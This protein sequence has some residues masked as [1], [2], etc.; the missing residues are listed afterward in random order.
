MS[1]I[2]RCNTIKAEEILLRDEKFKV[3]TKRFNV[4]SIRLTL[5][6]MLQICIDHDRPQL[7]VTPGI[8]ILS[9]VGSRISPMSCAQTCKC[10]WCLSAG[11]TGRTKHFS[12]LMDS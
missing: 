5:D 2:G 12:V 1:N 9:T 7:T 11:L 4:P 8:F 6:H 10:S 3:L